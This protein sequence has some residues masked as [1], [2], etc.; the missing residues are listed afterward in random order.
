MAIIQGIKNI[1][2]DKTPSI[3]DKAVS[4]VKN[5]YENSFSR[6][7]NTVFNGEKTPGELGAARNYIADYQTL[8]TRSWQS[9]WESEIA[10]FVVNKYCVWVVG[11]GLKLQSRP[12]QTVLI[13]EGINFKDKGFTKAVE[14]RFSIWSNSRLSSYSGM[15]TLSQLAYEAHKNAIVGGDCLVVLRVENKNLSVQL[16]DADHIVTP[17]YKNAAAEGN[18]IVYGVELNERGS[19]VAYHVLNDKGT[20]ERIERV[21]SKSG[22]TMAFLVYGSRFRLDSVR[23]IPLVS[24]VLETLK[25]LDRYKEATVGSA[26]ERAKIVLVQENGINST[27]ENVLL[28]KIAEAKSQG[29]GTAPESYPSDNPTKIASTTQKSVVNMPNG[30]T[31]K[32]LESKNELYFKDFYTTNIQIVCAALGIPAEVAMDGY[33]GNY[34]A[35]RAAIKS[36][37]YSMKTAREK[38]AI[39]FYQGVYNCW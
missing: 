11:T 39:Q 5:Y 22:N 4:E 27:G 14:S 2:K 38:F 36:W 21:G 24:T 7:L 31:L 34:S 3:V 19:H 23:G 28:G 16:I 26:E 30:S 6:I 15:E 32:A 8:R 1:F 35:S 10:Q 29:F 13:Q 18:R 17:I 9:Y 20:T 37:D 12:E 33:N 25:K